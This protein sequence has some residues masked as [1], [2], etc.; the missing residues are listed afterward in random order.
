MVPTSKCRSDQREQRVAHCP[1]QRDTAEIKT[2]VPII[3]TTCPSQRD[4]L[5]QKLGRPRKKCPN[6]RDTAKRQIVKSVPARGTLIVYQGKG[7][8]HVSNCRSHV[9]ALP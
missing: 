6:Q 8:R 9:S 1:N 7:A 4:T 2:P 5:S 3:G